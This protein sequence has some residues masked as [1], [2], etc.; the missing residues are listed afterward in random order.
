[1]P[2]WL[3]WILLGLIA[4]SL[5]KFIMPGRDPAG[6]IF[7]VFLGIVGA[8]LGG[9]IGTRLGWGAV[10]AGELDLRSIAIA[11]AGALLLLLIGRLVRKR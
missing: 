7:T 2:L 5:A 1:M 10:N 4:G 8:L 11:T 9:L 3:S 6:C